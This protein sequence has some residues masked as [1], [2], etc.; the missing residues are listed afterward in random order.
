MVNGL[1]AHIVKGQ[2]IDQ[3][4]ST[5]LPFPRFRHWNRSNCRYGQPISSAYASNERSVDGDHVDEKKVES[6]Q[7]KAI[8]IGIH[9]TIAQQNSVVVQ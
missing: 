3:D 4:L 8:Y 2:D 7:Q 9:R 1:Y 6:K 5:L